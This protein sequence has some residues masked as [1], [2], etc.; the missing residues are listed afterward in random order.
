MHTVKG[1]KIKF[2]HI[3]EKQK[4]SKIRLCN[5]ISTVSRNSGHGLRTEYW[6]P[7]KMNE[8]ENGKNSLTS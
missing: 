3:S 8:P 7:G 6:D 1:K 4:S 5:K 2:T